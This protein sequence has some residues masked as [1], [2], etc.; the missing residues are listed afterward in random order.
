MVACDLAQALAV[1]AVAVDR[2]PVK[3]E[4]IAPDV[5]AFEAGAPHSG[6]DPLDDE[7][8]FELGDRADDDD[9]GSAQ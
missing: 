7:V 4:W 6:A 5:A 9:D 2:I 1:A 3:L 8:A